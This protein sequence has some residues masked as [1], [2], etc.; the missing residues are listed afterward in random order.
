MTPAEF[1]AIAQAKIEQRNEEWKF[2]DVLNGVRCSLLA[3]INRSSNTPAYN[4]EDFRV[5]KD[6]TEKQT[7][8]EIMQVFKH[9][10]ARNG[11]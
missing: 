11:V 7:P 9:M 4:V 3:N 2:Q 8:E 1:F 5:M 6:K 10:E